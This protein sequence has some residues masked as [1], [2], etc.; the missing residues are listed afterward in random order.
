MDVFDWIKFAA[1]VNAIAFLWFVRT[2]LKKN[3]GF[4]MALYDAVRLKPGH[5]MLK[6]WWVSALVCLSYRLGSCATNSP[7]AI[8]Y[9]MLPT[10]LMAVLIIDLCE[11]KVQQFLSDKQKK[12][13]TAARS[14]QEAQAQIKRRA[15]AAA[16]KKAKQEQDTHPLEGRPMPED[17]PVLRD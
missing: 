17:G 15:S 4:V 12:A 13:E 6:V 9:G 2:M 16:R 7:E 14:A 8:V 1:L 5:N 3:T 11:A 10:L